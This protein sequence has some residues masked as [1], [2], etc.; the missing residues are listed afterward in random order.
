MKW[1]PEN[2]A[3]YL[4]VYKRQ[5]V[6]RCQ[7]NRLCILQSTTEWSGCQKIRLCILQ[8]ISKEW[9]GCQK[10]RLCIL[11]C[12]TE[13]NGCQKIRLCIL[14]YIPKSEVGARNQAVD[15]TVSHRIER[16][17]QSGC[18]SNTTWEMGFQKIILWIQQYITE[19]KGRKSGCVSHTT[20][21]MGCQ[22][23]R[24]PIVQYTKDWSV[25]Q[26]IS[27]YLTG[28]CQ[29]IRLWIQQYPTEW[30]GCWKS[31]CFLIQQNERGHQ[32]I[33]SCP[34]EAG[35]REN[36][37]I[38]Q[39]RQVSVDQTEHVTVWSVHKTKWIQENQAVPLKKVGAR[40]QGIL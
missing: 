17:R 19:G 37:A 33:R 9:S 24:L 14:H 39:M 2:Q 11:Q 25:W 5:R 30:K 12:T 29:K 22:K 16:C 1:V 36:Q 40:N 3:V 31:G 15:A 8:Y 7:K 35:V 27:V 28:A 32:K 20:W 23:I 4:T 38:S 6:K 10:I 21:E 34:N 26:K 13:W 18:V